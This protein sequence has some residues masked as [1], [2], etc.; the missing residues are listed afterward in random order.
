MTRVFSRIDGLLGGQILGF[1][2]HREGDSV[3]RYDKSH[4]VLENA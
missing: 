4:A 3:D 1:I 2:D